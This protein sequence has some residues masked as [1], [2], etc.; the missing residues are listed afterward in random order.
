MTVSAKKITILVLMFLL[1]ALF[2]APAASATSLESILHRDEESPD[3]DAIMGVAGEEIMLDD[4]FIGT[5]YLYQYDTN[6]RMLVA[7][8]ALFDQLV[9]AGYTA[10]EA[11]FDTLP[12]V[13]FVKQGAENVLL[14]P[15]TEQPFAYVAIGQFTTDTGYVVIEENSITY[16][17]DVAHQYRTTLNHADV[18]IDGEKMSGFTARCS[19]V[20]SGTNDLFSFSCNNPNF[21]VTMKLPVGYMTEGGTY[22]REQ[23]I[24]TDL[25]CLVSEDSGYYGCSFM[26]SDDIEHFD[27]VTFTFS[28]VSHDHPV[29]VQFSLTYNFQNERH[30]VEGFTVVTYE[31]SSSGST[32]STSSS[33]CSICHGSGTCQ[34]CMGRGYATYTTWGQGGS[35]KVTCT[36]CNGSGKC[37]YCGN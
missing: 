13:R 8:Q 16:Y 37:K 33:T 14:A 12:A 4:T 18:F 27:D 29:A 28:P 26:T 36:S 6:D 10:E 3:F 5:A 17:E 30:L 35:G 15:H 32:G 1:L 31:G 23:F 7:A 24:G 25:N 21:M 20:L 2:I 9:S 19:P 11:T 34:V 22:E